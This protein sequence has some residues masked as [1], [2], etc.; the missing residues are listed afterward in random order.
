MNS[1]DYRERLE[2]YT[3]ERELTVLTPLGAGTQGSVFLIA[4]LSQ[5]RRT[6]VNS[7]TVKLP[8]FVNAMF[9][10]APRFRDR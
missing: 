8:I 4:N 2:C 3:R 10:A 5:T 7:I 6:A 1:D 9:F